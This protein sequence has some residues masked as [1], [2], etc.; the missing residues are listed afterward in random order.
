MHGKGGQ[1]K[2]L[3]TTFPPFACDMEVGALRLAPVRK[4]NLKA[5][6][7]SQARAKVE[8][9][10]TVSCTLGNIAMSVRL[11]LLLAMIWQCCVK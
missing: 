11:Q 7:G 9:I 3:M 1:H 2:G 4:L 10:C 6:S 8:A 5:S